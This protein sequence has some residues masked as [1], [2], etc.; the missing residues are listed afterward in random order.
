MREWS[1]ISGTPPE[2][3]L[4]PREPSP[5]AS[6]ASSAHARAFPRTTSEV[7]WRSI[8]DFMQGIITWGLGRILT[9]FEH[10]AL[11]IILVA[12][13]FY[14]CMMLIN[15][16]ISICIHLF[17]CCGASSTQ[18]WREDLFWACCSM[19]TLAAKARKGF[20]RPSF[21]TP[22][23]PPLP[24]LPSAPPA[25]GDGGSDLGG[26]PSKPFS[27]NKWK[28]KRNRK[29][30]TA[31]PLPLPPG[32]TEESRSGHLPPLPGEV[33]PLLA[34]PQ[35]GKEL[36]PGSGHLPPK[37]TSSRPPA[38]RRLSS[39]PRSR[40]RSCREEAEV[41]LPSINILDGYREVAKVFYRKT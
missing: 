31:P 8:K 41:L 12:G 25:E 5:P 36:A 7:A 10:L 22:S 27:L 16:L 4:T 24:L 23:A 38:P 33:A 1:I 30:A 40:S 28:T 2:A 29:K 37:R 19:C 13:N 9:E 11:K 21:T 35:S 26:A 34:A 14:G 15:K 32:L 6:A 20:Q 18:S 39:A 3:L 17:G